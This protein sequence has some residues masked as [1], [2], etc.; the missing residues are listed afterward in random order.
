M[1]GA[2][3]GLVVFPHGRLLAV[4]IPLM[5][6]L[7]LPAEETRLMNPLV[8]TASEHERILLPDT[9]AGKLESSLLECSAE[10]Q[11]FSIGVP[12]IDAAV[13]GKNIA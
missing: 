2:A 1:V 8:R 13:I 6:A 3:L 11:S 10:V 5:L 12:Y 9:A 4:G 7:L